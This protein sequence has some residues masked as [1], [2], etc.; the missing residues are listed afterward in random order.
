MS[1]QITNSVG[2]VKR[3]S[4]AV[5]ID[6]PYVQEKGSDGKTI[7]KFVPR[8]KK[9]MKVFEDMVKRAIGFN[10]TRGDQVSVSNI[11]FVLQEEERSMPSRSPWWMD[12]GKKA[13][14]PLFN[15]GPGLSFPPAGR[16]A[17]QEVD[18]TEPD[19]CWPS[20]ASPCPPGA[21]A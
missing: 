3:L 6:G 16:E 9:D 14:K 13:A 8:N 18:S 7:S 21:G 19:N 2:D 1:R 10:E 17:L 4:A 20:R 12:Y 5:I 11:P 15:V